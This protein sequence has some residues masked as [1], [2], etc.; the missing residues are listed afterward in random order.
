MTQIYE[1]EEYEL[2]ETLIVKKLVFLFI[3]LATEKEGVEDY[4]AV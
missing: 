3:G 4:K 1:E 2:N